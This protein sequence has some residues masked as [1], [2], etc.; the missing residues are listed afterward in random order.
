MLGGSAAV[1]V[2]LTGTL[3]IVGAGTPK[4]VTELVDAGTIL[5]GDSYLDLDGAAAKVRVVSGGVYETRNAS[6]GYQIR[7]F[8]TPAGVFVEAG[9]TFRHNSATGAYFDVPAGVPFSN[10][11]TVA[12]AKGQ[13][14]ILGSLA[15]RG[16]TLAAATLTA[17]TWEVANGATLNLGITG[18]ASNAANIT[19]RGTGNFVG[20]GALA[21]NSDSLALLEGA[22]LTTTATAFTNSGA[23]ALSA[24]SMLTLPGTFT[25]TATGITTFEI[26]GDRRDGGGA[27]R[28]ARGGGRGD[29]RGH[30]EFP[31]D[32]HLRAHGGPDFFPCDLRI[33]DGRLFQNHRPRPR[34]RGDLRG[35]RHA[36]GDHAQFAR[37]CGGPRH[38][39]GRD[40]CK[41]QRRRGHR[42]FLLGE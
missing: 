4:L 12:V 23:L 36:D 17:G 5:H 13:F 40:A 38:A 20:L 26:G 41:Y 15:Q 32:D 24:G 33:E 14:N 25:Q 18:L 35:V 16:G 9:A 3:Q 28:A 6:S 19:V 29:A 11:G 2:P 42:D 27:A 37:E 10:L 7:P 1:T 34:A 39:I 22:D 30:G 8:N 21:T 31:T